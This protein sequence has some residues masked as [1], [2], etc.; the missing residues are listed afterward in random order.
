MAPVSIDVNIDVHLIIARADGA[1]F[2]VELEGGGQ[3]R[4]RAVVAASG[5]FGR[6]HRPDLPGPEFIGLEW[7][8]SLSSNTPRGVGRDA[9]RSA[10]RLAAHLA[11]D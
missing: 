6:P 7:Q 11:R 3:L 9:A 8:R 1:G 4:A 10:H 2:T 5:S